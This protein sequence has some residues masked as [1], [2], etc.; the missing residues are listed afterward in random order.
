MNILEEIL[1]NGLFVANQ[2]T[3][4][5]NDKALERSVLKA[6]E[7]LKKH[8][9]KFLVGVSIL[10]SLFEF[11]K[12]KIDGIYYNQFSDLPS[13]PVI[14][15]MNFFGLEKTFYLHNNGSIYAGNRK[16]DFFYSTNGQKLRCYRAINIF[17]QDSN[18]D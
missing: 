15:D 11:G 9:N 2:T 16:G 6:G 4:L 13:G 18:P 14:V 8:K 3:Y 1:N 12:Y 5:N 17:C 10:F 7:F